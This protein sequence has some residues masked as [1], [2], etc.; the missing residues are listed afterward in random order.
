MIYFLDLPTGTPMGSCYNYCLFSFHWW[1]HITSACYRLVP[2][3][4]RNDLMVVTSVDTLIGKLETSIWTW[5]LFSRFSVPPIRLETCIW[6]NWNSNGG[7]HHHFSHPYTGVMST[8][9]FLP[10]HFT[11]SNTRLHNDGPSRTGQQGGNLDLDYGMCSG[12]GK[13]IVI[14]PRSSTQSLI[15]MRKGVRIQTLAVRISE[16]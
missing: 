8:S 3:A 12:K 4:R 1:P 16:S 5:L 15:S 6:K 9:D 14:Q 7:S 2:R 10:L 13:T 11:S